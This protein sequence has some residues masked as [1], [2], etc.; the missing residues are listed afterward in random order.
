[1]GVVMAC[2]A[3]QRILTRLTKST[4]HPNRVTDKGPVHDYLGAYEV[5]VATT[6]SWAYNPGQ[7]LRAA[8]ARPGRK[9]ISRVRSPAV[10]S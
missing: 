6:Y 9:T 1:M 3:L 8:Y 4:D 2:Q 5:Y 10:S 7:T